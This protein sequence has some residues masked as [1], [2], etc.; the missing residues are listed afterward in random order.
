MNTDRVIFQHVHKLTESAAHQGTVIVPLSYLIG[1][2]T[3]TSPLN[4]LSECFQWQR[5]YY[6]LKPPSFS[7]WWLQLLQNSFLFWARDYLSGS[8]HWVPF[9]PTRGSQNAWCFPHMAASPLLRDNPYVL[10]TIKALLKTQHATLIHIF[11]VYHDFQCSLPT[12]QSLVYWWSF[13]SMA[14]ILQA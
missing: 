8:L 7:L 10:L 11:L 4:M 6:L 1:E 5:T 2:L 9:F 3:L 13:E 14:K 12:W